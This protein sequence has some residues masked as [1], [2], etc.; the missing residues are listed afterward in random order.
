MS[1]WCRALRNVCVFSI[2]IH[3]AL[4]VTD[5]LQHTL[6]THPKPAANAHG[7]RLRRLSHMCFFF[8]LNISLAPS[9]LAASTRGQRACSRR[10]KGSRR[11]VAQA[12]REVLGLLDAR[13]RGRAAVGVV[14]LRRPRVAL[15]VDAAALAKAGVRAHGDGLAAAE[16]RRCAGVRGAVVAWLA[17][18]E[19]RLFV[20]SVGVVLAPPG[21]AVRVD[22]AAL[23]VLLGALAEGRVV[24]A[25]RVVVV[26]LGAVERIR[27]A[28][29][30]VVRL[31]PRR[32]RR[33]LL[34]AAALP[35]E[36]RRGQG[37]CW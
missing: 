12:L 11:K 14:V 19:L 10:R 9:L 2:C 1:C 32:K 30:V 15:A 31:V 16:V 21:L 33:V 29:L 4:P 18:S 37:F 3:E 36:T 28:G 27:A 35:P 13:L 6:E 17:A 26:L 5:R 34:L 8:T 22:A 25:L 7:Q 20:A 24:Q 23:L